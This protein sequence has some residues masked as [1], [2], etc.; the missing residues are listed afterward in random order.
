MV[1]PF[2]VL[3]DG[4]DLAYQPNS[5]AALHLLTLLDAA[6]PGRQAVVFT[7]GDS[8]HV[9]PDHV[10]VVIEQ[11]LNHPAARLAWEQRRLPAGAKVHNADLVHWL[12]G[13]PALFGSPGSII[14]PAGYVF[15]GQ[16]APRRNVTSGMAN[17]LRDA[18]G[19]GGLAR[20]RTLLWPEDLPAPKSG[21]PVLK[22]PPVGILLDGDKANMGVHTW[23]ASQADWD[24]P[25]TYVLYQG[26]TDRRS[27]N[28]L[29][30]V[31]SW[32]AEPIGAYDPLIIAGVDE[33]KRLGLG[34]WIEA[35]GF[36]DT[37]H[38]L[39]P[40]S[41]PLLASLFRGCSAL[42][43]PVEV[44]PWGGPLRL[45]LSSGR[46]VVGL[47]SPWSDAIVGPAA[48]LV[49]PDEE[50]RLD[51]RALGAALVATIVED[52]V[53]QALSQAAQVRVAAWNSQGFADGLKAVYQALTGD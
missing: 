9:L 3:Y 2:T 18:F 15:G 20:A 17:R 7:P 19:Q 30:A 12:D 40:L 42:L 6:V 52:S 27:L 37:I 23:A 36:G 8:F 21:P 1:T 29:L 16:M 51:S 33:N 45:A 44:S 48:Y 38:I 5:P 28:A 53:A 31:W 32:A 24:M 50:G 41:M 14:S 13:G 35:Q 34:A 46:P 49:P 22:L 25:E 11:T 10:T 4:W 43:H 26:P 39:P 47:E